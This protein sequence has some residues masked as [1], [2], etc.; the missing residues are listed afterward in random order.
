M[1]LLYL[2]YRIFLSRDNQH[3][4]NRG[5]LIGIYFVSFITPP[6]YRCPDEYR[7]KIFVR[8]STL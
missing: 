2:S 1:L 8:G 5:V 3:G 4:F 6:Y 7:R